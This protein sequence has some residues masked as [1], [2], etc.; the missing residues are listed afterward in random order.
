MSSRIFRLMNKRYRKIKLNEP[1]SLASS[2]GVSPSL[3]S[4]LRFAFALTNKS[5][6]LTVPEYSIELNEIK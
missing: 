1:D 5:A 3:F 6:T 2:S 4:I